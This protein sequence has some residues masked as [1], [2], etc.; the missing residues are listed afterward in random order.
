[1]SRF[2]HFFCRFFATEKQTPQTFT[3]LEC[4]LHLCQ[5]SSNPRDR[6]SLEKKLCPKTFDKVIIDCE[7][8]NRHDVNITHSKQVHHRP[9]PL[10]LHPHLL[11]AQQLRKSNKLLINFVSCLKCLKTQPVKT[12]WYGKLVTK[13][14]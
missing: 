12:H 8:R 2:T 4:M 11:L 5:P 1:M 14:L 9:H 7:G 3:I 13:L 6:L 10:L